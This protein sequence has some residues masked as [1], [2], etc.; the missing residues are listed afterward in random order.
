M[1]VLLVFWIAVCATKHGVARQMPK[2]LLATRVVAPVRELRNQ[3][4]A[5]LE[6]YL[7]KYGVPDH[8]EQMGA[9]V[10]E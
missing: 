6:A 2:D 5:L 8:I 7:A 10:A 4:L 9:L 1:L 3:G